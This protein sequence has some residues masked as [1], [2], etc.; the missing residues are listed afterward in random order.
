MLDSILTQGDYLA[1]Y[2]FANAGEYTLHVF[3]G[4]GEKAPLVQYKCT[5][6]VSENILSPKQRSRLDYIQ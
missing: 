5:D 6:D 2:V 3:N 1:D 4:N